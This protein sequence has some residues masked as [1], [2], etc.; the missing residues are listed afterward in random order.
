LKVHNIALK[1]DFL[2]GY[3]VHKECNLYI[4]AGL[5]FFYLLKLESVHACLLVYGI[6]PWLTMDIFLALLKQLKFNKTII[7]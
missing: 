3:L 6:C 1:C 4:K 5:F 7:S 2:M